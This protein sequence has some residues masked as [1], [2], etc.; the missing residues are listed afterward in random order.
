MGDSRS[1]NK[2]SIYAF[3]WNG[4]TLDELWHTKLSQNY[5]SDYLYDEA[6]K[7]LLLVEVVKK[8]GLI[9]MG[10]SAISVKKIE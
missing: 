7:E 6:R 10:A 8:E 4:A 1:Y 9:D 2:N 5:L 3:A